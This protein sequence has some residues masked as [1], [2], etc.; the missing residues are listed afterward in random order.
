MFL[1]ISAACPYRANKCCSYHDQLLVSP[2]INIVFSIIHNVGINN[3][4]KQ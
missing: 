1:V 3:G 4:N 2:A